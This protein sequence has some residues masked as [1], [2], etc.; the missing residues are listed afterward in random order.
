MGRGRWEMSPTKKPPKNMKLFYFIFIC[1]GIYKLQ[2]GE[3][4]MSVLCTKETHRY[5]H[6]ACFLD[7]F[8]EAIW[9][10]V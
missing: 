9:E 4:L 8:G 10:N 6:K 2:D 1:E 5:A 7:D 3:S